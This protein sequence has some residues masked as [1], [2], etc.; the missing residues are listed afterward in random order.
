MHGMDAHVADPLSEELDA[1]FQA[2]PNAMVAARNA[3]ADQLRKAGDKTGAARVKAIKRPAPAAWA[4][5]QVHFHAPALL[6]QAEAAT[7][8]V[9]ALHARD[10][11]DPR[12]LMA[13][14]EAQRAA[15]KAVVEAA[16]EHCT[17][18]GVPSSAAHQRRLLSTLQAWLTG[19]ADTP[20]G[21]MTEEREP[22]GFDA[23]ASVGSPAPRPPTRGAVAASVAPQRGH[24]E[25]AELA[26][27]ARISTLERQLGEAEAIAHKRRFAHKRSEAERDRTRSEAEEKARELAQLQALVAAKEAEFQAASASLAD[28]ERAV[29]EVRAQLA[30]ARGALPRR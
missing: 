20:P 3:L 1:L 13:A 4:L 19:A 26:A 2:A 27:R 10:A 30:D 22:G 14:H 25:Q 17:R 11:V 24:D 16:L 7:A 28:A 9:R 23:I 29:Q 8:E 6:A 5:N 21:R 12:A 15:S 18:A